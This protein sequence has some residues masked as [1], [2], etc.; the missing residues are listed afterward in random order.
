MSFWPVGFDPRDPAAALLH[1]IQIDSDDG[2]YGFIPGTD[3]FFR[4][5][6]DQEYWGSELITDPDMQIA[7]GGAAPEGELTMAFFQDP[8]MPDLIGQLRELGL[9]YVRGHA[10]RFYIQ[11]L[12]DIAHMYAP[13]WPPVMWATRTIT[14][15]TM[16]LTGPLD[17]RI[18]LGFESA[19]AGL[20]SALGLHYTTEDHARLTGSANPSLQYMPRDD[21]TERQMIR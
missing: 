20:N 1:L 10:I 3:G 8:G 5:I 18:T 12:A 6:A 11:P 19:F 21:F 4:D 7:M 14:R 2:T 17:R 13:V 15:L 9:D 16:A